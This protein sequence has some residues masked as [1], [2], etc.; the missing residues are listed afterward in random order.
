MVTEHHSINGLDGT[1]STSIAKQRRARVGEQLT[2]VL[3]GSQ[4]MTQIATDVAVRNSSAR[5]KS[6]TTMNALLSVAQ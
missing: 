5:S 4:V 1:G 2:V 6:T 3:P